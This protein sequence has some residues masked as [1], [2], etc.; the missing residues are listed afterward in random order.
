MRYLNSLEGNKKNF[1]EAQAKWDPKL[2]EIIKR[3]LQLKK[4]IKDTQSHAFSRNVKHCVTCAHL[5][6]D[7]KCIRHIEVTLNQNPEFLSRWRGVGVTC[8]PHDQQM[9]PR[10]VGKHFYLS[11]TDLTCISLESES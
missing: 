10:K 9:K 6:P 2:I 11:D 8:V 7:K 3:T 4:V 1:E 5:D